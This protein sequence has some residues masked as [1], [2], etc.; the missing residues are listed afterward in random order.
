MI[1]AESL[2]RISNSD[3]NISSEELQLAGEV[4]KSILSSSDVPEFIKKQRNTIPPITLTLLSFMLREFYE[5]DRLEQAPLFEWLYGLLTKDE[6]EPL[7]IVNFRGKTINDQLGRMLNREGPVSD[8]EIRTGEQDIDKILSAKDAGVYVEVWNGRFHPVVM[9]LL[10]FK[11]VEAKQNNDFILAEKLETIYGAISNKQ[12][13][14]PRQKIMILGYC[15]GAAGSSWLSNLLKMHKDILCLHMPSFPGINLQKED[16]MLEALEWLCLRLGKVYK[17]T[18]VTHGLLFYNH[19]KIATFFEEEYNIESHGFILTRHPIKRVISAFR[20]DIMNP[21]IRKAD[22][23]MEECKGQV[24]DKLIEVSGK[25]FPDDFASIGFYRS[26]ELL[27]NIIGET[28]TGLPI[29]KIEELGSSEETVNKFFSYI[30]DGKLS[31]NSEIIR[32]V[33]NK[34]VNTRSKRQL[35]EQQIYDA[36]SDEFREAY[37]Y[38]V[39]PEAIELYKQLG[40]NFPHPT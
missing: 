25:Q 23:S 17:Y 1:A 11:L 12:Y 20:L 2:K 36:W 40:Y 8:E 32:D 3:T 31:L 19:E 18:G 5:E 14:K 27:N 28:E 24:Y 34:K 7:T 37:H 33:Q 21:T 13:P 6:R 9:P 16:E 22:K 35:S 15:W 39:K 38:I 10:L 26:C 29:F 4:L 30:S